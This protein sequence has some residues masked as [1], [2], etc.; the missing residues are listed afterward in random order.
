MLQHASQVFVLCE[1]QTHSCQQCRRLC[2]RI[3]AARV[4]WNVCVHHPKSNHI[5]NLMCQYNNNPRRVRCG[6]ERRNWPVSL[7]HH[8]RRFHSRW[9]LS[10]AGEENIE[11]AALLLVLLP[12]SNAV[13]RCC[14]TLCCSGSHSQH[15]FLHSRLTDAPRWSYVCN[16]YR[17][18]ICIYICVHDFPF[19]PRNSPS[20]RARASVLCAPLFGCA[21]VTVKLGE[22][23]RTSPPA[24]TPP[25]SGFVRVVCV[26]LSSTPWVHCVGCGVSSSRNRR[27]SAA[28]RDI[29]IRTHDRSTRAS[30]Y[31]IHHSPV[32]ICSIHCWIILFM[33]SV[34]VCALLFVHRYAQQE[35][36]AQE[37][38]NVKSVCGGVA[39][40]SPRTKS[41]VCRIDWC[42]AEWMQRL[43][44]FIAS[45]FVLSRY[46]R[47]PYV[48][49][50]V[51][52]SMS[53][54]V[55]CCR[56]RPSYWSSGR[57]APGITY[58]KHNKRI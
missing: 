44:G 50:F 38:W 23:Q 52:W 1:T 16:M 11:A 29:N 37:G 42:C 20:E 35:S 46:P 39:F 32:H 33:F 9:Q 30:S 17:I 18:Y 55:G 49:C 47:D 6:C 7:H 58:E 57:C 25:L 14:T 10:C 21:F 43:I 12:A 13:A 48:M 28:Y 24:T 40:S 3:P 2:L 34:Y 22:T 51:W 8:R 5:R 53:R 36:V 41:R 45:L 19:H 27:R 31:Q 4:A 56:R 54:V 15:P 26:R